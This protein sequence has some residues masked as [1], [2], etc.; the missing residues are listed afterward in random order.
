MSISVTFASHKGAVGVKQAVPASWKKKP[1]RALVERVAS[2]VL[3]KKVDSDQLVLFSDAGD[4]IDLSGEIGYAFNDGATLVLKLPSS[5]V[6]VS[7]L[8]AALLWWLVFS[9]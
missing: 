4:P 9:F 7:L 6:S 1:V 8:H 5:L 3:G 2:S